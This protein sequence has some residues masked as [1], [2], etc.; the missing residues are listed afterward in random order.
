MF[1]SGFMIGKSTLDSQKM[2]GT[3]MHQDIELIH[4][5]KKTLEVEKSTKKNPYLQKRSLWL[6]SP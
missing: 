5:Y 4:E 6:F 1:D 2:C 3:L